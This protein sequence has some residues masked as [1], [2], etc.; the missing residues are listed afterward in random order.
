MTFPSILLILILVGTVQTLTWDCYDQKCEG[1]GSFSGTYIDCDNS[2]YRC[3]VNWQSKNLITNSSLIF[4]VERNG[5]I[6][7]CI[8]YSKYCDVSKIVLPL[9][10]IFYFQLY[11]MII[12]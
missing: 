8:V 5:K 3:S 6:L 7:C 12:T 4:T 10:R 2:N 11:I 1:D 9:I